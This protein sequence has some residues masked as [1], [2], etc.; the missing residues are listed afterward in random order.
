MTMLGEGYYTGLLAGTQD[1]TSMGWDGLSSP[2]EE[3]ETPNGGNVA[4]EKGNK[5]RSK[6]FT[7]EEDLLLVS[8]WLNIGTD[9]IQ[10]TNQK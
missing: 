8:A 4:T 3:Q 5:K 9:P 2:P 6:N 10:G 7:E 1:N